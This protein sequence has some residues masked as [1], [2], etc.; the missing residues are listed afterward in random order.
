MCFMSMCLC[1]VER[2]WLCW[3]FFLHLCCFVFNMVFDVIGDTWENKK[4][5]NYLWPYVC[6][7][8]VYMYISWVIYTDGCQNDTKNLRFIW[9]SHI[10]ECVYGSWL[11]TLIH[12]FVTVYVSGCTVFIVSFF[13]S[14]CCKCGDKNNDNKCILYLLRLNLLHDL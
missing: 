7:V 6:V 14:N 3:L 5:N 9:K 8:Y 12:A 2:I 1:A 10:S 13:L 11:V 4:K